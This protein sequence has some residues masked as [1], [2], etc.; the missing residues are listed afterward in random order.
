MKKI[1]QVALREFVST[2]ATKG[3]IIGMLVTP[4]IMAFMIIVMPR[5]MKVDAPKISGEVA[6][7]DPTG[8]VAPGLAAWLAPEKIAERRQEVRKRI[9]EATPGAVKA[10][11]ESSPQA[12]LAME[13]SLQKALGEVPTFRVLALASGADVEKEKARLKDEAGKGHGDGAGGRL[14]VVTVHPD[15]VVRAE[16]KES[17]GTY[18]IFVRAKLDDRVQDEIQSGLRESIVA[19][20]VA[21]SGLDRAQIAALTQVG[22]VQSKTVTAEGEQA[23][24]EI[25]NIFLPAGFMVLLLVSVLTGGQ[26]LLTTMVEEKSNR[27]VEVLLSA[28]SP[29]E[30]MAGKILGQMGVGIVVLALYA[31]LGIVALVSFAMLGLLEFKLLVYLF[32]FFVLAYVMIASMMAAI[33]SAV[34]EMREAQTLMTPVM[35]L[36]MLPWLLWMPITRDP[37]SVFATVMS[38]IPPIGNFVMI[39]R[40]TSTSPP[41]LWQALLAIAVGALGVWFALWFAAKIFRVGL[42]MYGKPPTFGTLI[43]WAR[44]S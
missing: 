39:L 15:A 38:F 26:Y 2:V 7:V 40:L 4:L 10:V 24:N 5:L 23:T 42:L 25:A 21:A 44:M 16:G 36:I 30:L 34:S 35:L 1:L 41:P 13:Q 33:G 28:V 32:I 11:A 43:R 19:A 18:D 9:D 22:R 3:F 27:I 17:F 6:I 8:A 29:M 12:R 20:R 37:N 31:G 14:A